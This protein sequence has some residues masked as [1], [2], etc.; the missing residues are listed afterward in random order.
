[1][2][3]TNEVQRLQNRV[4]FFA[5]A[6]IC[7]IFGLIA[8]LKTH[9]SLLDLHQ[10]QTVA[11]A[12]LVIAAFWISATK[13]DIWGLMV[14]G[15]VTGMTTPTL[16]TQIAKFDAGFLFLLSWEG[17]LVLMIC[18]TITLRTMESISYGGSIDDRAR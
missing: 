8:A 1:M 2:S 10:Q 17:V 4:I 18:A 7:A 16:L 13:Y 14:L 12:L 6:M 15:W 11:G 5:F 3:V 9:F